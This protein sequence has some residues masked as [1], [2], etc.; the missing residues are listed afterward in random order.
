KPW[1]KVVLTIL[2]LLV[3]LSAG[4][5]YWFVHTHPGQVAQH[6]KVVSTH[7]AGMPDVRATATAQVVATAAANQMLAA[8]LSHHIHN[9]PTGANEFFTG[10]AYHILNTEGNSVAVV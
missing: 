4:I 6:S 3:I 7:P 1:Q 2:A 10:G 5:S 8:P 9:F